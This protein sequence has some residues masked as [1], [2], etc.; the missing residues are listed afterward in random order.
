MADK[1][2][3]FSGAEIKRVQRTVERDESRPKNTVP[4]PGQNYQPAEFREG[5]LVAWI[6]VSPIP[7]ATEA[8]DVRTAGSLECAL[9]RLNEDDE[10]VD[11]EET[12]TVLNI[13]LADS[14]TNDFVLVHREEL[15]GRVIFSGSGGGG[16]GGS[17][18]GHSCGDCAQLEV[19]SQD[20]LGANTLP[21]ETEFFG[22]E[23]LFGGSI[24]V[25]VTE[26]ECELASDA[27]IYDCEEG[28]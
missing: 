20:C 9:Y 10:L 14:P 16:G 22:F 5:T 27:L 1:P 28:S 18:S 23:H 17:E 6:G 24:I 4:R 8:G 25:T 21:G 13:T 7:A 15:T 19:G 11:H 12:A 2:K 26:E 3:L